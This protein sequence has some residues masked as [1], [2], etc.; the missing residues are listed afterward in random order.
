MQ[1]CTA[2]QHSHRLARSQEAE[3]CL[4]AV[5]ADASVL[6]ATRDDYSRASRVRPIVC[7]SEATFRRDHPISRHS[8][9]ASSIPL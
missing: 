6:E 9:S 1:L 7:D 2:P 5:A 4:A 3:V 8:A